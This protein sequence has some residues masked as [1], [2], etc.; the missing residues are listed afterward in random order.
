MNGLYVQRMRG[1]FRFSCGVCA[2]EFLDRNPMRRYCSAPCRREGLARNRRAWA[3]ERYV[4]HEMSPA[5]IAELLDRFS[6]L[7]IMEGVGSPAHL[8]HARRMM[9]YA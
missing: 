1:A 5:R 2:K 7:P 9:A 4:R 8:S 6:R 3:K